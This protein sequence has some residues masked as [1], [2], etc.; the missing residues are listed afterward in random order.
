MPLSI[1]YIT[2]WNGAFLINNSVDFWY[3]QISLRAT[4]PGLNLLFFGLSKERPIL[5]DHTKAHIHE[6]KWISHEIWQISWNPAD[7]MWNPLAN[8]INQIIQEKLFSFMQCSGKAMSQDF[9]KST[10]FHKIC[11]ISCEICRILKDQQLPGMVRPMFFS[12][13][14]GGLCGTFVAMFFEALVILLAAPF[15]PF[16]AVCF[17]L[18]ILDVKSRKVFL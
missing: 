18:A 2:C 16:L 12:C 14:D 15:I 13:C 5:G 6:I 8:L 11:W 3:W 9:T 17:V 1:S 4:V 10:T 7:F